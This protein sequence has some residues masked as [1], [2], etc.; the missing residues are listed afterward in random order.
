MV[1]PIS[2]LESQSTW[3][4]KITDTLTA[5][6]GFPVT[7]TSFGQ[8]RTQLN[9][10]ATVLGLPLLNDN[11]TGAVQRPKI[12]AIIA[13]VNTTPPPP[14]MRFAIPNNSQYVPLI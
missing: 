8:A 3:P 4:A 6:N 2:N 10:I 5:W 9:A 12:N 1:D 14:S 11:D 13:G 7:L